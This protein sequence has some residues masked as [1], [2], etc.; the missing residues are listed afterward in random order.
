MGEKPGVTDPQPTAPDCDL[1]KECLPA[2]QL[3]TLLEQV[4]ARTPAH[5]ERSCRGLVPDHDLA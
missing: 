2:P 5:P 1:V 3:L 4:R